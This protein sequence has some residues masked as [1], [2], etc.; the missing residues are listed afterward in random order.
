[1]KPIDIGK[2][3]QLFWDS[4]LIDE[5]KTTAVERINRPEF[6]G[7]CCWLDK[8]NELNAVSYP[9]IVKAPTGYKLYYYVWSWGKSA[10]YLAVIESED[11]ITW[12]R[13]QLG[14]YEHPELEVNNVCLDNCGT[15]SVFYDTNLDCPEN[16]RYK[17]V[18][19]YDREVEP[20]KTV[21]ELW[22]YTSPDGYHFKL[23]HC[24]TANGL[25]DSLNVAFWNAETSEYYCFYRNMH[26]ANGSD[27]SGWNND[28]IRDIRVICSQDFY[29][30]SE[31]KL[32]SFDDD[33]DYPLYTNNVIPYERAP[34]VMIG[35]PVRYIEKKEWTPNA[36][37]LAS[38]ELKKKVIR[39]TEARGGLALTDCI[40]M[41]SHDGEHWHRSN[42]A[43][44]TPGYEHEHNWVYGD[45]YTA[46]NLIDSGRESYYI[47]TKDWHRSNGY[48][49]PINRFEIRK[50]GFACRAAGGEEAILLTKPLT[51]E[52]ASLS[53]NF[54]TSA[55]GYIYVNI[56]D[57][58]CKE[59]S[60]E[61][62]ELYGDTIDRKVI[63]RELDLLKYSGKAVRI[64][65]RMRDAQIFSMKFE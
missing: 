49:K 32:I 13:P 17:A 56:L 54:A 41:S 39:E 57:E 6:K 45:C 37:Q 4:Y 48:P 22:C 9:C 52:G 61:S 35:F 27:S 19:P 40:F 65:F 28:D 20:G 55:F 15:V 10:R 38:S 59:L 44:M 2:K 50:D 63:F 36:E 46:Y 62:Y 18:G 16:E 21:G 5:E 64:K 30:W 11:G 1:M 25:F 24:I 33:Y 26:R 31:P 7:A 34:Q 29:N 23:S 3:R 51:F 47:Y 58:D 12:T 14:I 43:F 42:E 60:G 53:I 8:G